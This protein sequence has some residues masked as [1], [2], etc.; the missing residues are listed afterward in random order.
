MAELRALPSIVSLALSV[1][2]VG[3]KRLYAHF[4]DSKQRG[5]LT[6]PRS[7]RRSVKK[8]GRASE[9]SAFPEPKRLQ[10]YGSHGAL[11]QGCRSSV[12][13]Q[14][15]CSWEKKYQAMLCLPAFRRP[16]ERASFRETIPQLPF[17]RKRGERDNARSFS[18]WWKWKQRLQGER[19]GSGHSRSTW[20]SFSTHIFS[21][22]QRFWGVDGADFNSDSINK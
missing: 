19:A 22:L 7:Q 11:T 10:V 20:G 14:S 5:D 9:P 6:C 21:P 8:K 15:I 18:W 4:A 17:K 13:H 16:L 12:L 2:P 1:K 3:S